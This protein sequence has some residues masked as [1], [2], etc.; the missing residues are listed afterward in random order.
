VVFNYISYDSTAWGEAIVGVLHIGAAVFL[1]P[2]MY[3]GR[4]S[5]ADV[6]ECSHP[7]AATRASSPPA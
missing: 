1:W 5:A 6:T 2:G 4:A 7:G 3:H